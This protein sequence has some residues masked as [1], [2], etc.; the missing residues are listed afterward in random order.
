[1][2]LV[3]GIGAMVVGTV[4][5][6]KEQR[7]AGKEAK[8]ANQFER[9][10]ANLQSARQKMEAVREGRRAMAEVQQNAEN[11]GVSGSSVGQGGAGSVYSQTNSNL[12]FLDQYGYYSDQASKFL[13]Q[14]A[15]SKNKAGMWQSVAAAGEKV[16]D[17]SM[18]MMAAGG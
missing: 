16:V 14:S 13:Q 4:M 3:A 17:M 12:S 5:G 8:K 2:A 11:Q 18:K 6:I 1:M 7:K 10:R 15:N 9:Q